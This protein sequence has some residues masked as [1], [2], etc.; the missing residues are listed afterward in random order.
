MAYSRWAN[1]NQVTY[2]GSYW[3]RFVIDREIDGNKIS[4]RWGIESS[5]SLY[6]STNK[7]WTEV[8]STGTTYTNTPISHSGADITWIKE[9]TYT[10]SRGQSITADGWV[11]GLADG[12]GGGGRSNVTEVS[13]TYPALPPNQMSTPTITNL[14]TT[15][16][17]VNWT[18]PGTNGS[19]ITGYQLVWETAGGSEVARID[20]AASARSYNASGFLANSAYRVRIYAK[21]AAGNGVSSPWKDFTTPVAVPI[22]PGAPTVTR[23]SDTSH[24]LAWTR[25]SQTAGPYASQE[26]LRRTRTG[27]VW[28]AYSVIATLSASSTSYVDTTT[29]ANKAYDYQVRAT[30]A[31]GSATS[32]ASATVWTTPGVPTN[33]AAAKNA[34]GDIVVTWAAPSGAASAADLKYEVSETT[35]GSTW[36][37]KATTAA[38]VLSYT[39]VSPDTALPHTYRVRAIV[40]PTGLVGSGLAS[41]YVSTNTVQLLTPPAAPSN[42]TSS[43]A[44]TADRA[45]NIELAWT[46][47]PLDSSPQTAYTLQHRAVGAGTWTTVGPTAGDVSLYTLPANTYPTG[48]AFEWR[49]LTYGLHA[50]PGPYSAIATVQIS[51]VPGVSIASPAPGEVLPSTSLTVSWTFSDPDGDPQGSWEAV[52]FEEG[53]PVEAKVGANTADNTTF[54]YRLQEKGYSVQVRVRDSRGLWSTPDTVSFTVDY[55]EPP[56]PVIDQSTWDWATA[57]VSLDLSVP[58]PASGEVAVDHLEVWR[59]IDDGPWVLLVDDLPPETLSYLDPSPTVAGKNTYVVQAVSALP[60]TAQSAPVDVIT[61]QDEDG[62]PGVWLSAGPGLSVVG[63]LRTEVSIDAKRVRERAL[64]RYAGRAFPVE[65]EGEHVDETWQISGSLN[66]RWSKSVD[67]PDSPEAWLA[68]GEAEG[69]FLLRAPDLFGAGPIYAYVSV[70]GPTVSRQRGGN[71]HTVSFSATRTEG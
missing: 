48:S 53:V 69:P 68:L 33:P 29:S 43:P 12:S 55:P 57:T 1:G 14:K 13:Y 17:T 61:P 21:S 64:Q 56:I 9:A 22:A 31:S 23:T 54:A 27:G 6:D 11:E 71:V 5:A 34:A 25:G 35:D 65:H 47:N 40:S 18:A 15:T 42:L 51:S 41:A 19:A 58:T 10:L 7:A 3:Y 49:V 38:G 50:N 39:H 66:L 8:N 67:P 32:A 16:H 20:V 44:G 52:L 70:D 46:H 45:Q 24:S 62:R 36:T 26:V 59:S 2:S 30:N 4:I 63:C 37:V 60:S 28:G